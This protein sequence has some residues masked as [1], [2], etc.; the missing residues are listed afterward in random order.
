[1]IAKNKIVSTLLIAVISITANGAVRLPVIFQS[2]MVLQRNKEVAI[3]GFAN[4]GEKVDI[5]FKGLVFRTVTSKNGKWFIKLSPQNAGGPYDITVK[6]NTDSIKLKNILFG[7]VWICGGQSNMQFTLDQMGY[8]P[9]D[10]AAIK[11]SRMRI[12]TASIDMDYVPKNDL[13]GGTWK[14][15][16]AES[17]KYFSATAYFFGKL[18][19]DS[20][21]VPIGLIS[22]NLGATSIETWMSPEALSKFPQF[23]SYYN[24]YLAPAKSFKEITAAFEKEKPEWEA[25]YY[26]RGKGIEQKWYLPETDISGWKTMEIPSWWEDKG[27]PDFDGAVWFRKTFDLPE[28][29]K[30]DTLPLALNQID[31]YDI[32]WIN[33]EKVGEGYGNQ[34]WR[35]YKVPAKILKPVGNVIVVRVFDTDGKGGMYSNAIW[36][37]PILLGK[38]LYRPGYKIDAAKF[39]KPHVVNVSPFSTPAVLYNANIAPITSLAIKGVI[40]YQGESNATRA[41]EYRELFPALINDWRSHFKQGN[42]PFLFVQLANYMQESATPEESA[43]AELRDAQ[44]SVLKLPNT[45]MAVTIDIGEAN[46]IHPKDK[47][48]VGKRL[49]LAALK[50]AYSKDIISSG[51]TYDFMEIKDDSIVI[52]YA[53]GTGDLVTKNKYGYVSGF[54]IAGSDNKFHWAKAYLRNNIAVVYSNEVTNPKAVRYA[55]S[56]NPGVIDLYN[57]AGLPAAPFRTDTL[58]LTTKGKVFSENPWDY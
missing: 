20:M 54:A 50:V 25:K 58:P 55:W 35:N 56:D 23:R 3:W 57:R 27:L 8:I 14:E 41:N 17:I 51:P 26:L 10:T 45:G 24:E 42:F 28:N 37:N 2:N 33:G 11:N 43:W 1:M 39:P 29:F 22:D 21:N 13:M 9:K 15:A 5:D 12:F 19:H 30:G 53:T 31:D 38:W 46:N 36:G 44:A 40:W 16:S 34:N 48:D 32:V 52:H 6:G 18:L 7:D 49:G 4:A 47:M